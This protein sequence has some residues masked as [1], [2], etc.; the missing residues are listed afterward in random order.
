MGYNTHNVVKPT[1]TWVLTIIFDTYRITPSHQSTPDLPA[2]IPIWR[3]HANW[4]D[5]CCCSAEEIPAEL[6]PELG[7]D[8]AVDEQVGGGVDHQENIGEESNKNTPKRESTKKRIL[9]KFDEIKNK[10]LMHVEDQSREIAKNKCGYNHDED[11]RQ[12]IILI[13]SSIPPPS[14]SKIYAHV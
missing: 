1:S 3:L 13:S 14:N 5:S 10:D 8:D 2:C 6:L 7:P 9:A 4:S 12:M 11:K